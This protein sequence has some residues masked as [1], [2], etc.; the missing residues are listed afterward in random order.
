MMSVNSAASSAG[1]AY[2]TGGGG[3][4]HNLQNDSVTKNI[5][6]QIRNAQKQLQ[7]IG[8]DK[9]MTPDE[10]VKKRQEIQQEI[11]TLNQQLQQHLAE[12]RKAQQEQRAAE[13]ADRQR[14]QN[15]QNEQTAAKNTGIPR[16]GMQAMLSAD[17]SLKQAKVQGNVANRMENRADVLKAEIKQD[18][19]QDTSAKKAEL[20]EA[21]QKAETA[22]A[23]QM[24][25]LAEANQTLAEAA[26]ADAAEAKDA[27]AAAT[28]AENSGRKASETDTAGTG[29]TDATAA[30]TIATK[31]DGTETTAETSRGTSPE[32]ASTPESIP[33]ES[34]TANLSS[35]IRKHVDIRL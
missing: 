11:A 34:A 5:Q 9:N 6:N 31:K 4:L 16:A 24:S 12:K 25:S 35:V 28:K 14:N 10:K 15:S 20:A 1:R 22:E 3:N 19:G 18:G 29:N 27:D 17:T 2:Q 32:T 7:E 21:Q 26:K 8:A 13:K 33:A 30:R 23:A